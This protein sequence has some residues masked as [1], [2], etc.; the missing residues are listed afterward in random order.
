MIVSFRHGFVFVAVPRTGTHA[1]RTALGPHLGAEDW[2]QQALHGRAALPVP[3]LAAVG[4]GHLTI[5]QV[6]PHLPA[7]F[8]ERALTFAFVREPL[9]RFV[10]ACAFLFRGD[11][12]FARDPVRRV[13]T[14]LRFPRFRNRVLLRPQWTFLCDRSGALAVDFVGRHERFAAD[15]ASVCTRLGLP[16]LAPERRNESPR[17][18][19]EALGRDPTIRGAVERLYARDR[20][21]FGYGRS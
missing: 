19:V 3:E 15:L 1:V 11:A 21:L 13:H 17:A 18:H 10:S 5:A 9:D 7:A 12:D 8:R 14:A 6:A 16:P 2:R 4:H 20:S